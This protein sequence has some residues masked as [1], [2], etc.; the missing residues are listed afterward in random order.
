MKTFAIGDPHGAY[1]ALVQCLEKAQF[2]KKEDKLIV[3]GDVADGWPFVREVVD[4]LLTIENLISILGNHD[5]WFMDYLKDGKKPGLWLQQGGMATLSS[6]ANAG[7]AVLA[8]HNER[9][10]K[11]LLPWY[12]ENGK[13][14]MHGGFDWHKPLE[15][16]FADYTTWDRKAY[17]TALYWGHLAKKY[18]DPAPMKF[19]EFDEI[20]VGHTST[21]YPIS[22][23]HTPG[24]EPV[25]ASN[26][27]NLDT[28]AGWNGK[29]TIMNVDTKEWWQ[30][31]LVPD[32]YPKEFNA[33]L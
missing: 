29:L 24:T 8:D 33:R 30:S 28:G 6:Y 13:A 19:Q 16:N 32:L 4:E 11:T 2:N 3:L 1:L 10:F 18:N 7:E 22:K 25:F 14:F 20:F 17:E 5:V 12:V 9:Y 15:D 21:Q 26:L 23:Y 31:D 27:I